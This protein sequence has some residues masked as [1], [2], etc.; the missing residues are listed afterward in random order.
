M[1]RAKINWIDHGLNMIAVIIGVSLAFAISNYSET[2]GFKAEA[3]LIVG[4]MYQ[5]LVEDIETYEDY[6]IPDNKEKV[7]SL[8][9]ALQFIATEGDFDSVA[10]YLESGALNVNNYFPSNLTLNSIITSGKLDLIN[11]FELR[12][13]FML[14]NTGSLEARYRGE[15]QVEFF[16]DRLIPWYIDNPAFFEEEQISNR[17]ELIVLLELYKAIVEN[18]IRQY[19]YL[20]EEAKEMQKLMIDYQLANGMEVQESDHMEEELEPKE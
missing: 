3:E 19:V 18:K 4:S 9:K 10:F 7:R 2:R 17:T 11:D 13:T 20:L 14:F 1:S 16:S 15:L 8:E 5:E 12:K 6:Q